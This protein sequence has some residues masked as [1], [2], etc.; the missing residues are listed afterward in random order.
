MSFQ[1][2]HIVR[3][4]YAEC[5]QMGFVHHSSFV[6]YFEEARTEAMRKLGL[7]YREM[8]EDGII[9]PVRRMDIVYKK[10]GHYD[11]LL[12][13]VVTVPEKPL[14]RCD[15]H[16]HTYNE[17]NELLNTAQIDLMFA[18]K[19]NLRPCPLPQKY[20]TLLDDIFKP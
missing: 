11:D 1:Y 5:D 13:I 8:E 4:R 9:M 6:L 7:I 20:S 19:Q 17:A 18:K 12:R 15:I 3:V 10:A 2:E 16:Y 14:I